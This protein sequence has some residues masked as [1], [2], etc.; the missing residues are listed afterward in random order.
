M[1]LH[2]EWWRTGELGVPNRGYNCFGSRV[3]SMVPRPRFFRLEGIFVAPGVM[4][5]SKR[6]LFYNLAGDG[7]QPHSRGLYIHYKDS[8]GFPIN[9][10]MTIPNIRNV[11]VI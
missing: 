4:M 3:F 11:E 10:G 5:G 9:G 6:L 2:G 8:H 1:K 7:H